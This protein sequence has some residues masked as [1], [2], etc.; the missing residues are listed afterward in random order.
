MCQR[1]GEMAKRRMGDALGRANN[2]ARQAVAYPF[3]LDRAGYEPRRA[4]IFTHTVCPYG[5]AGLSQ[6]R[7]LRPHRAA[8][9]RRGQII[10]RFKVRGAPSFSP[11]RPLASLNLP[12]RPE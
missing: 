6:F 8:Q 2:S 1:T 4:D 10:E 7:E 9:N 3:R 5:R 12:S 11:I